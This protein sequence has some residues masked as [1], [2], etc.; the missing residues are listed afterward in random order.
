MKLQ[1]LSTLTAVVAHG[2]FAA[3]S[4]HVNLT[5]SAVSLQM[6]Q[7]ET[8]FRR[9]LF[10]RSGRSIKP[11]EFALE[12]AKTVKRATS[13]IEAMRH[14]SEMA[15]AGRVRLGVTESALT[16]LLPR[17][18]ADLQQRAPQIE[19]A[20]QRGSTPGLLNE[21]KAGKI[22]AAV[23]IRPPNGGSSRIHWKE[24]LS[25][26]FVLVAPGGVPVLGIAA[27]LRNH[28]WIRLDRELMAGVLAARFVNEIVPNRQA[29]VDIPGIDAIVAMVD[30]GI[31][32]SVLPRLRRE[33]RI[34]HS[35]QVIE[36]GRRAPVRH[37]VMA[38]RESDRENRRV[39]IVERAF[40]DAAAR[41]RA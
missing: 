1:A 19:L 37:M 26:P 8:Y 22:D 7:L 11:N 34:V 39:G 29:L 24:L 13:E 28:P 10:D 38:R 27:M 21:L 6:K 41:L 12:L 40:V 4:E 3:A 20:I 36:L 17:A 25:E 15:P 9:P 30:A 32:V 23:V 35:V 18:F 2:S 5:P 33:L 31:G 16:T 14:A